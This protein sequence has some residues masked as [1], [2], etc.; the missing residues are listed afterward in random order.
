MEYDFDDEDWKVSVILKTCTF[1]L[2]VCSTSAKSR[3]D[4]NLKPKGVT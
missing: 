1:K 3:L 4:T 2:S